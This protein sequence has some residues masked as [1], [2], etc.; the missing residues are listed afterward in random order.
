MHFFLSLFLVLF[1]RGC[2]LLNGPGAIADPI[3]VGGEDADRDLRDAWQAVTA[4]QVVC[5]VGKRGEGGREGGTD[6]QTD[7]HT[8]THTWTILTAVGA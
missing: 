2:I 7:T 4:N 3:V 1:S 8:H 6:R 5:T